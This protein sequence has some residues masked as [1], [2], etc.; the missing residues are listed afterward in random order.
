VVLVSRLHPIGLVIA[1]VAAVVGF[2][3][4]AFYVRFLRQR[5]VTQ[6]EKQLVELLPMLASSLRAGFAFQQAVELAAQQLS[7]P[8]VDELSLLL[9]DVNLGATMD[10]ALQDLG[11]RVGSPDLD[12][13]ITAIQIQ[14][15]TG[16]NLSEVLDQVAETLRERERI[17]GDIDTL[18][19]QQKLTGLILSL[20]PMGIGGLL[21][22]IM[23]DV[24]T[25]LFTETAGWF[26]IGIALGLQALGFF[27]MR[28]IVNIDI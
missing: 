11:E 17:R 20:Y 6:I 19:A 7:P 25:L 9:Q 4:P 12:M 1:L 16:G 21:L 8:L 5:R 28:R 3:A 10:A 26:L 18:T 2:L 14:R 15:L 24:W 22:L 27:A 23:P 13:V